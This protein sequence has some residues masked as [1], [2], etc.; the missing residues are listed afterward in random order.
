M[1]KRVSLPFLIWLAFNVGVQGQHKENLWFPMLS[2]MGVSYYPPLD[3][4]YK[5]IKALEEP[6]W[7]AHY[8]TFSRRDQIEIKIVMDNTIQDYPN[9]QLGR[10]LAQIA[11]NDAEEVI[12][13]VPIDS[14]VLMHQYGADWGGLY[15]FKPKFSSTFYSECKLLALFKEGKGM[16]FIFFLF[17]EFTDRLQRLEHIISF[18]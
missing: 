8:A 13:R 1:L 17:N 15:F 14:E 4:G 18:D 11:S 6:F 7:G 16:I 3:A 12:S 2:A 5:P 10:W 9:I